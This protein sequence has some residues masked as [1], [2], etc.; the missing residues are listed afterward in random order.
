MKRLLLALLLLAAPLGAQKPDPDARRIDSLLAAPRPVLVVPGDD[1]DY[2]AYLASGKASM[3]RGDPRAAAVAFLWAARL[4]P[5]QAEPLVRA[6]EAIWAATPGARKRHAKD[7]RRFAATGAGA[8]VDS[9]IVRGLERDPFAGLLG[10]EMP[11]WARNAIVERVRRDA[12]RDSSAVTPRLVLASLFWREHKYDSTIAHVR[13]ALAAG[14][15]RQRDGR[16]SPVYESRELL[17]YALGNAL[18]AAGH[19]A[20]A[21]A[22]YQRALEENAG[23]HHAHARLGFVAWDNWGDTATAL[24]EY[25]AAVSSAPHDAALRNDYGGTLLLMGKDAEALAQ[26]EAAIARAPEYALPYYNAALA[27]DRLGRGAEARRRYQGFLERAPRRMH[28]AIGRARERVAAL[29]AGG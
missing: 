21:R 23:F 1:N 11:D 8:R 3:Q 19:R 18:H 12:A 6:W 17:H 13:G 5:A 29:P 25:E 15:R 26:F 14:D 7:D 9:L 10:D 22:A 28:E 16:L 20:G 27:A 2:L 24:L 4:S